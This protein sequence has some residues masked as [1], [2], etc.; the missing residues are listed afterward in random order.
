MQISFKM[1]AV[2][3]FIGVAVFEFVAMLWISH[4]KDTAVWPPKGSKNGK[5]IK[6]KAPPEHTWESF[7]I[8]V[9]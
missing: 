8:K 3:R 7:K 5:C 2:V 6:N 1:Y 9:Y 4:D